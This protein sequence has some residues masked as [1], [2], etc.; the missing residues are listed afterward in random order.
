M[1]DPKIRYDKVVRQIEDFI[2]EF[3]ESLA[4]KFLQ[5][6][7]F[8]FTN[9]NRLHDVS[10]DLPYEVL[11]LS[12]IFV[13][14]LLCFML[15]NITLSILVTIV[16]AQIHIRSLTLF[17]QSN[18]ARTN[19][20]TSMDKLCFECLALAISTLIIIYIAAYHNTLPKLLNY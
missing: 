18:F 15:R 5:H 14:V 2:K 16:L 3:T 11:I 1:N 6:T 7:Q 9:E 8:A 12:W 4:P 19:G 13:F 10:D 17:V 20:I